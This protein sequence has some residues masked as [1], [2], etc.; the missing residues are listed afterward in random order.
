[1]PDPTRAQA[2][3][4][5]A[6]GHE[7]AEGTE[8]ERFARPGG[9]AV[10]VDRG[11]RLRD[12]TV[13]A[14]DE[15]R[16]VVVVPMTFGRDPTLVADVAKSLRWIART[17]PGSVALAAPFGTQDHLVAH[18][19]TAARRV[20]AQDPG[21]A[22][23]IVARASNPFDDA[24][25]HRLAHLVRVYG[26]GLEVVPAAVVDGPGLNPTLE[27]LHTLGFR[28]AAVVP[29]GFAES[30]TI[31]RS[32]SIDIEAEWYGPLTSDAVVGRTVA[33]RVA[34]AV[35]DLGHGQDGIDRGL[36]A[37]HGHGYA[38]SHAVTGAEHGT[39]DGHHEHHHEHHHDHPHGVPHL[40][41]A[42]P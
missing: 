1:M 20:A 18:L 21:A 3:V 25:L 36:A 16:S 41:A 24:E 38:H 17:S 6:G 30:M 19:R 10:A 7:S 31:E 42:H 11:R 8:L 27:R 37:D 15:E 23:V 9:D 5:L 28:R 14:L 4:I 39:S 13:E 35:H 26:S 32:S 29:A 22:L 12:R 2:R 34:T 40:S 33:D